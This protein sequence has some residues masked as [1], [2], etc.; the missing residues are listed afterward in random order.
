MKKIFLSKDTPIHC[1][2]SSE[3]IMLDDHIEGYFNH[4]IK[5]NE[6]DVVVDVG[7]NIGVLGVRLSK[8]FNKIKIYCFEPIPNIFSV[9]QKNCKL[10]KNPDFKVFE[11]GLGDSK[12]KKEFTYCRL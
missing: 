7:A 10:T 3:A 12:E 6:G 1:L 8:K 4:G 2:I 9:L 5:I 11:N